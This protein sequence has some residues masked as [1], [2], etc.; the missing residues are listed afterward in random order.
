MA[1]RKVTHKS[2]QSV[3]R[4]NRS[5][6][7]YRGSVL[8]IIR[9]RIF[10]KYMMR[11]SKRQYGYA[12]G[13]LDHGSRGT[14]PASTR[15]GLRH[16]AVGYA[17]IAVVR[18]L[19]LAPLVGI[20]MFLFFLASLIAGFLLAN[21]E[22]V[23]KPLIWAIGGLLIALI[24]AQ[25]TV[26]LP[27]RMASVAI[28]VY[29]SVPYGLALFLRDPSFRQPWHSVFH[30]T[31]VGSNV[32]GAAYA[33]LMG[34]TI[35]ACIYIVT[36]IGSL[37]EA[38]IN[39]RMQKT[40]ANVLLLSSLIQVR[41]SLAEHPTRMN[42]LDFKSYVNKKL[43]LA[44]VVMERR[45]PKA[46]SVLNPYI[47]TQL[48]QDCLQAAAALRLMQLRAMFSD[49]K[50]LSSLRDEVTDYIGAVASGDY[51]M[52]PTVPQLPSPGKGRRLFDAL[53]NLVVAI[54]P[55]TT[56]E[57][58]RYLGVKLPAGLENWVTLVTLIWGI[59]T[60][61]SVLDP[62]YRTKISDLRDIVS[63]NWK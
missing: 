28:V 22:G 5:P 13:V 53:R 61:V 42:D 55:F 29:I 14:L 18:S 30:V 58:V 33:L 10:L 50:T 24:L 47:Q 60:I 45:M 46:M 4:G 19:I 54:I 12:L 15:S 21:S 63:L 9:R 44:A 36:L 39:R 2:M 31:P 38:V 41:R 59:I 35:L 7:H 11:H 23:P 57:I 6:N 62:Y 32:R 49:E 48:R 27:S 43:E 17:H 51:G 20:G 37:C 26:W 34:G 3:Y 25:T 1:G 16:Y 40:V 52:L 8:Y 56:F